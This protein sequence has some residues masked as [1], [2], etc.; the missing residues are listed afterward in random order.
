LAGLVA[1]GASRRTTVG[2]TPAAS[3]RSSNAS[4]FLRAPSFFATRSGPPSSQL[5]SCPPRSWRA[6]ACSFD[7]AATPKRSAV[8]RMGEC[9]RARRDIRGRRIRPVRGRVRALRQRLHHSISILGSG[10]IL[11]ASHLRRMTRNIEIR[12]GELSSDTLLVKSSI[13]WLPRED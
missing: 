11:L 4:I 7:P 1:P 3:Y 12:I 13:L 10:P 6:G 8:V 2:N 9:A 5:R